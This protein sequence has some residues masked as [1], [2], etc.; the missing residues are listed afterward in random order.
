MAPRGKSLEKNLTPEQKEIAQL[1]KD[2]KD[3]QKLLKNLSASPDVVETN[4]NQEIYDDIPLNKQIRVMSL[5]PHKLNLSTEN[6]GHGHRYVFENYGE[7]RKIPYV[8]LLAINQKHKNFMEGGKYIILD[9][10]V[11]EEE[12]PEHIREKILNKENVDAILSS[13]EN[14][15]GLFQKANPKQQKVISDIIVTK[16]INNEYVDFNLIANIDKFMKDEDKGYTTIQDRI[17]M[18]QEAMEEPKK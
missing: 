13:K 17:R 1:K 2:L 3:M 6:R 16:G 8:D 15:I 14:A 18:G 10:R 4:Q 5:C 12:V 11:A 9:D 7:V